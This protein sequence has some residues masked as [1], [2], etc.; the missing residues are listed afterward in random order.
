MIGIYTAHERVEV[1]FHG[2]ESGCYTITDK[3]GE[4]EM[5]LWERTPKVGRNGQ[6]MKTRFDYT[7]R[8]FSN[9][10]N[11]L[12]ADTKVGIAKEMVSV[13]LQDNYECLD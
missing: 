3:Y 7:A 4:H 5:G 8:P 10:D 9:I 1:R 6:P 13:Y 2:K 12:T 11:V